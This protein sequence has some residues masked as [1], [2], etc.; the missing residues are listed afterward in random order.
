MKKQSFITILLTLLM[1]IFGTKAFAY[2][3]AVTN[4]DGITIYYFWTNNN[5]EL[6]VTCASCYYGAD[7]AGN[8]VIPESVEYNGNLYKVTTIG[9][10]TFYGCKNLTSITIPNSVKVI[11]TSSFEDCTGLSSITIPNSVT[12]I[13]AGAFYAC[14]GLSSITIP[15]SVTSIGVGAFEGCSGLTS[16]T[17]SN[18]VKSIGENA[19]YLCSGLTSIRLDIMEPYE[20][21]DNVF[22]CYNKKIYTTA[23]LI[24]PTGKKSVYQSIEGWKKFTNIVEKC[25]KPTITYNNDKII[26][27]CEMEDVEFHYT[28]SNN[29][30]TGVG[31]WV[32]FFPSIKVSV[33]A[34]KPGYASSDL[35]TAEIVIPAGLRGDLSGDGIV[36]VADHVEL[37]NIIMAQ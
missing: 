29:C 10:E 8:I 24:V 28:I 4:A 31:S 16:V 37:S 25:A 7:Y 30:S 21:N 11:G 26:F 33:Y 34:V 5:T 13:S 15:N 17:I 14:T 1:S 12:T 2:H 35:S 32:S 27:S 18:S 19:F 23:T 36:N 3:I 6:G 9:E 20:I 22:S